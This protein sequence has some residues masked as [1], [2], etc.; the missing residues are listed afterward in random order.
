MTGGAGFIGSH[1]VDALLADGREVTVIDDLSSGDAARVD[2]RAKLVELDIVDAAALEAVVAEAKPSAIFHLAAQ[3][4]VIV[5]AHGAALANLVFA[6]QGAT[7]VELFPAGNL[8]P[9]YWKLATGVPGL[10][11]R[12]LL[13]KG[14]D[15][16]VSRSR[17][18]V[19]DIE[20][21]VPALQRLL[22]ELG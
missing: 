14:A 22:D 5:S 20:V 18:L 2:S 15:R 17:M 19:S 10:T 8:V 16:G 11:Y 1:V 3:A 6:S 21:D 9:D 4:S 7:V 13:G 12:Y